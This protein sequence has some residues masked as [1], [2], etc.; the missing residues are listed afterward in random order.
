MSKGDFSL[1]LKFPSGKHKPLSL[2]FFFFL[3]SLFSL[4][5]AL[6]PHHFSL[7]IVFFLSLSLT[8]EQK[9]EKEACGTVMDLQQMP[10]G[11]IANIVSLTTP[12]EACRLSLLS[13]KFKLAAESDA[14][15]D[16]FL[17]P[18]TPTIQSQSGESGLLAA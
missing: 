1:L 6:T 7:C 11:C 2:F 10:E 9:K 16:K 12:E 15:W 5:A 3:F 14:V 4:S 8:M 18:E 17:P 13:K